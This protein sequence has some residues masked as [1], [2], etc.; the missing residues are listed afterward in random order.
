[1]LQKC[2]EPFGYWQDGAPEGQPTLVSRLVTASYYIR[3]CS[4]YFPEG[5]GGE[6]YGIAKGRTESQ[7]NAYTGGWNIDNTTR[8]I[9]VNGD[10]GMPSPS[11]PNLAQSCPSTDSLIS[12]DPWRTAS[13]SSHE[14][15]PGGALESTERVPV[16]IVP[17]GFHVSDAIT[18]NGRVNAGVQAAIDREVGQLVEWVG[19]WY[20]EDRIPGNGKRKAW[21]GGK[22]EWSA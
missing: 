15:R 2:D 3:Q 19:E 18:E 5:P 17:G 20:G 21:G 16:N 13:V 6:T 14:L 7:V 1:M 11:P 22:R 12:T 8:L 4:M 9:Y 10:Y